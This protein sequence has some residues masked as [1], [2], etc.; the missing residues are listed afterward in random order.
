M[1]STIGISKINPGP[2]APSSLPT[3][4][5]PALV[6]AQD[7]DHLQLDDHREENNGK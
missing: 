4:N 2:F 6:L 7:A 1:R 5:H 3:K